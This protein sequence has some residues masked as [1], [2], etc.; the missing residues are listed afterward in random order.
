MRADADEV[1]CATTPQPLLGIGRWYEDFSQTSDDEVRALLAKA[2]HTPGPPE[3]GLP[4]DAA[5]GPLR[6]RIARLSGGA[7]DYDR[8][9]EAIGE[10]RFVLLGEASHG[11]HEFYEERARITRRLIEEKGFAAVAVEADWP[12]TYRVNRYV[13]GASADLDAEEALADFR[14]F[15]TWMWRNRVVV[16]FL[17]WLRRHNDAFGENG[18]KAGFYGLDLYALHGAMKAC[19]AISKGPTRPPR[20]PRASAMPV[21]TISDRIL[22]STASSPGLRSRS[23]ARMPWSRS[24]P[25]C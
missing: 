3:E 8:L 6:R 19:C 23:P 17:E 18:P 15:P 10:A 14:R 16:A 25:K 1:V 12:D 21:S 7:R 11:T 20:R 9:L 22:R 4:Q 13:Q 5:I 2:W 24:S